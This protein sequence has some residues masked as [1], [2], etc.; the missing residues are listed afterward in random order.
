MKFLKILENIFIDD[1]TRRN[2]AQDESDPQGMRRILK[3][4][5]GH[6]RE[7]TIYNIFG[8]AAGIVFFSTI[9]FPWWRGDVYN[10]T[11]TIDAYP[12]VLIHNLPPEGFKYVI[13]TPVIAVILLP[14]VLFGYLFLAFWGSTMPGK[15]GR[16][17]L[18]WSGLFMLAYAAGFFG[19]LLFACT[20]VDMPVVG[21]GII[22][23]TVDVD[24]FMYF[25]QPYYVAI[26]AGVACLFSPLVHGLLPIRLHHRRKDR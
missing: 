15:K 10:R 4:F 13:D 19:S 18:M 1:A 25:L 23:Y 24:V 12:F 21:L 11:Y 3:I 9:F 7:F 2:L 22:H 17:F 26:G 8:L 20:L 5:T 16:L 14:V 6:F